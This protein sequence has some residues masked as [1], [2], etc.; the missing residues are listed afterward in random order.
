[1]TLHPTRDVRHGYGFRLGWAG[2]GHGTET[3]HCGSCF[4]SHK[5]RPQ[6]PPDPATVFISFLASALR[7]T[8]ETGTETETKANQ[9]A[10]SA[11]QLKA[12]V[13]LVSQDELV[14][15]RPSL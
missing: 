15:P 11:Q 2:P 8:G 12:L 9:F 13:S 7:E 6:L 5:R 4:W 10:F 3:A 1:M 14:E